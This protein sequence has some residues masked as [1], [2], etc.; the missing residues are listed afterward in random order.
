M[1]RRAMK[2]IQNGSAASDDTDSEL[3][4]GVE[5]QMRREDVLTFKLFLLLPYK[6]I[7]RL[8]LPPTSRSD[9]IDLTE[10]IP[11][12]HTLTSRLLSFK[13]HDPK[14]LISPYELT[15]KLPLPPYV[16][17]PSTSRTSPHQLDEAQGV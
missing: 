14:S 8:P 15:F 6:Q 4:D 12:L 10:I 3:D 16:P 17:I 7:S 9:I 2:R 1:K 11:L 5:G 13:P